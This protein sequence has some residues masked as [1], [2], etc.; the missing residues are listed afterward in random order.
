MRPSPR[1]RGGFHFT[2]PEEWQAPGKLLNFDH[3]PQGVQ[4]E[5]RSASP[6]R[7]EIRMNWTIMS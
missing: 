4:P 1:E 2:D 6:K 5:A 3:S 7:A